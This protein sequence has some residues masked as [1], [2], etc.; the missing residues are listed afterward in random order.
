ME[1]LIALTLITLSALFSGL[2]LGYFS[3]DV[4][5]LR[6][7]AKMGHHNAQAIYA[8]RKNG[9]RLLSTLLLGN[10]AVNAVLSVYLGS[11]VSGVMA[12][13]FATALIFVFGEILPQ[14]IFSRFA[15]AFGAKFA[16][17]VRVLT[18]LLLP[19]TFPIS[20]LLDWLLGE[21][22]PTMYSK[23]EIMSIISEHEDSEHSPIDKDEERIVHGAL[24]FSHRR[25]E[26]V[27][28]PLREVTM[29]SVDHVINDELYQVIS[30]EGYSRYP[31]YEKS[32]KN[33]VGILFAKDLLTEEEEITIKET[34]EALDRNMLIVKPRTLLDSVLATMLKSSRHIAIVAD[35]SGD[36]LGVIT[37]EDII[38]EIIQVEIED[39]DDVD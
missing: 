35:T 37:L 29:F 19:I 10:V 16:P 6:R 8:L 25:V 17:F 11:L 20:Y 4:H 32:Q 13:I 15:L 18:V 5:H 23:H 2:T 27:M 30:N 1:Y 26:Q 31:V 36:C 7:R 39:E 22:M 9:N 24:Q 38:E 3:L 34:K 28:T 14:A 33:I 21:E 12:S